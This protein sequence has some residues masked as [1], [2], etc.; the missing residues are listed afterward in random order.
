MKKRLPLL[1]CV[2]AIALVA[3]CSKSR[4]VPPI[5]RTGPIRHDSTPP[6]PP[7]PSPDTPHID[8][9]MGSY[10][11]S[12]FEDDGHPSSWNS[13]P[14]I[15]FTACYT[16]ANTVIFKSLDSI[17]MATLNHYPFIDHVIFCD[18]FTRSPLN[19]YQSRYN[20]AYQ[21]Q[22]SLSVDWTYD[23]YSYFRTSSCHYTGVK[24]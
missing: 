15:R 8:T 16:A 2:S 9:F 18:T 24:Q 7:A 11:D 1:I 6:P 22:N 13:Y 17:Q 5:I 19:M 12:V 21:V 14:N 3:A 4:S 20:I 10:V 23:H